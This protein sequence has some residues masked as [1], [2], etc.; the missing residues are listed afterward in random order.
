MNERELRAV[1]AANDIDEDEIEAQVDRWADERNRDK[2]ER[3]YMEK[4]EPVVAQ[5]QPVAW[6]IIECFGR[7]V[8]DMFEQMNRGNWVDDH[9]HKVR[10]NKAML[11]LIP[12][13]RAAIEYRATPQPAPA[14]WVMLTDDE[15]TAVV[16][17]QTVTVLMSDYV[18]AR[19]LQAAFITKQGA[20]P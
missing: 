5:A 8:T 10:M 14:P 1:L 19:N 20:K 11:D 16:H 7:G 9:G 18:F 12:I 15:I 6:K 2:Q 13:V 3:D 4:Q 17:K